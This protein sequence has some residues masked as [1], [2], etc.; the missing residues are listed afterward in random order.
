MNIYIY[1]YIY[2]RK[3]EIAEIA[4]TAVI[5][6]LSLKRLQIKSIVNTL[7]ICK[8]SGFRAGRCWLSTSSYLTGGKLVK[9]FSHLI[10][11]RSICNLLL[12]PRLPIRASCADLPGLGP[13]LIWVAGD[14]SQLA[15]PALVAPR[16]LQFPPRSHSPPHQGSKLGSKA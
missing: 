9:T 1:I 6:K 11:V 8:N 7:V 4:E 13:A 10:S 16:S 2:M 15:V 5:G 14:A 3:H 12:L